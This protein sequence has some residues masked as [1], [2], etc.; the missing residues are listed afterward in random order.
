MGILIFKGLTGRRLYKSFGVKGLN[1]CPSDDSSLPELVLSSDPV[2]N[3]SYCSPCRCLPSFDRHY[4]PTYVTTE[5]QGLAI[6]NFRVFCDIIILL[7]MWF[8]IIIIIIIIIQ[9]VRGLKTSD[10]KFL[11]F[12]DKIDENLW[13]RGKKV[14]WNIV[15]NYSVLA[16][17][18]TSGYNINTYTGASVW[19]SEVSIL[20]DVCSYRYH[21][22]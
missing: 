21:L 4:L 13:I 6:Y 10:S 15:T 19:K 1:S 7:F 20:G 11:R 16:F 5:L 17:N 3:Y 18:G 8:I 12:L 9:E 14:Q 2:C 22:R